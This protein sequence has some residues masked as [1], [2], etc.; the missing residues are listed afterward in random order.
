MGSDD[1]HWKRKRRGLNDLQRKKKKRKHHDAILIV[2][3]GDTECNYF[4]ALCLDERLGT[5]VTVLKSDGS[6]AVSIV[7]FALK[8]YEQDN[9]YTH[10]CG[11]FDKEHQNHKKL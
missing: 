8:K 1:L 10:V 5:N 4:K 9:S 7:N 2:C 11:V 6:D 3:E